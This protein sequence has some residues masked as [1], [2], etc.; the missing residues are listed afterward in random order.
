[1]SRFSVVDD[2]ANRERAL[3]APN[4]FSVDAQVSFWTWPDSSC[5]AGVSRTGPE[6][7]GLAVQFRDEGVGDLRRGMSSEPV[8]ISVSV[9]YCREAGFVFC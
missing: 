8:S 1:M 4:R 2:G 3:T 6:A 5:R 7:T 9:F